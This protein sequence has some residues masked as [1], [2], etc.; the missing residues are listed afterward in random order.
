MTIP[1]LSKRIRAHI[2]D[3]G[4]TPGTRIETEEELAAIFNVSRY[5][6]RTILGALVQQGVLTKSPRRGTY[7]NE[8]DPVAASKD[9]W[10]QYQIGS[11]DLNE[12]IEARIVVEQAVIPLVVRR[13]TPARISRLQETIDRMIAQKHT[14]KQADAADQ[15]FHINLIQSSGNELLSSFSSVVTLLFHHEAYRRKYWKPETLERLAREHQLI[16]NAIIDGNEE[17]ALE[18]H[19]EHL[20][21][22][23][24]VGRH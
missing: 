17:L 23:R 19:R 9:L 14:P 7:V 15:D 1:E 12:F 6:I 3:N 20:S 8:F 10:F 24:R 4:Y 21:F 18:R 5:K 22:S 2:I 16:L 13:V 11:Y